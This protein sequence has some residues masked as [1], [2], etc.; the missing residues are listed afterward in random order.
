MTL[1]I[2]DVQF[3]VCEP[4]AQSMWNYYPTRDLA[5]QAADK[6]MLE[7]GK[8]YVV[9]TW[10]EFDKRAMQAYL[11]EFRLQE[12]TEDFYYQMLNCL[13][14]MH[15][16]GA[17]GFFICE[18]TAGSITSQ[19]VRIGGDMT[20]ARYYGASVDMS[21]RETWITAEKIAALPEGPRL[22][23]FKREEG[24]AAA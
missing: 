16:V 8:P 13:P 18:Y 3:V 7:R 2:S 23:W 14:P 20:P 4:G 11:D 5:E 17:L 21:N 1:S 15:R 6:L 10:E 19:F 22:E 24:S 12:I 9:E